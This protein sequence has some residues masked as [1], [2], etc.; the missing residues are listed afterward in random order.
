MLES[1]RFIAFIILLVCCNVIIASQTSKPNDKQ[2]NSR[3]DFAESCIKNGGTW[4]GSIKHGDCH[5]EP[6]QQVQLAKQCFNE[7]KVW[8]G[9]FEQGHCPQ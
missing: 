1:I 3:K 2:L 4:Q 5:Y 9:T 6:I 8:Q 7:G